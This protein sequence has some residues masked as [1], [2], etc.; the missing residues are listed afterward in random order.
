L[1]K[2]QIQPTE[3]DLIIHHSFKKPE[4]FSINEFL[5]KKEK[6][7]VKLIKQ[8]NNSKYCKEPYFSKVIKKQ[9]LVTCYANSNQGFKVWK[10]YWQSDLSKNYKNFSLKVKFFLKCLIN[11]I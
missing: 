5:N 10:K 1:N 6:W 3:E 2:L 7:L 4:N 11:L 8:N 9:W